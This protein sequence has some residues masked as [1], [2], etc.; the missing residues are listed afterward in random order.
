[1]T[2][3]SQSKIELSSFTLSLTIF[4]F[5]LMPTLLRLL[6]LMYFAF[7]FMTPLIYLKWFYR[8]MIIVLYMYWNQHLVA[9][10]MGNFHPPTVAEFV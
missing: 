3:N 4:S 8:Y 2:D 1:M 10:E 7:V 9:A 5:K 6:S